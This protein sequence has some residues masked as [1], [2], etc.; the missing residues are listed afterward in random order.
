VLK[1]GENMTKLILS[2]V[3]ALLFI[4]GFV[5][6]RGND[7]LGSWKDWCI[8]RGG[9]VVDRTELAPVPAGGRTYFCLSEDGRI[10]DSK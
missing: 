4:L 3:A 10:I 7:E 9:H 6:F 2:I 8:R 5:L 1:R